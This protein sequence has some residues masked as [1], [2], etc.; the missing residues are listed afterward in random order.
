MCKMCKIC[1]K[2]KMYKMYK[3][4]KMCVLP[5]SFIKMCLLSRVQRFVSFDH[6]NKKYSTT[7][8]NKQFSKK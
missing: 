3:M 4:C 6:L 1:K 8:S 7:I 2:C 5:T